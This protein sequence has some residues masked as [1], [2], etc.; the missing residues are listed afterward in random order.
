M[1]CG[2]IEPI[3]S[4]RRPPPLERTHPAADF[5]SG[6]RREGRLA[7]FLIELMVYSR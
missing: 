3:S 2:S 1:N 6:Q 5:S 7:E 4:A